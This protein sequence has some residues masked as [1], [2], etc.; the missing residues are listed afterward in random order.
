M[1]STI[2]PAG[3]TR[4]LIA[5]PSAINNASRNTAAIM[6]CEILS[7]G[8]HKSCASGLWV[9]RCGFDVQTRNKDARFRLRNS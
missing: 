5:I 6:R 9:F 3:Q 8:K 4:G 2:G 7:V 1:R